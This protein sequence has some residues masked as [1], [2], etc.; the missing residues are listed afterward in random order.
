M[1]EINQADDIEIFMVLV[2]GLDLDTIAD[3][4]VVLIV[5]IHHVCSRKILAEL[6]NDVLNRFGVY[7]WID[8]Q[9]GL[10]EYI[11]QD[12]FGH[13]TTP[14]FAHVVLFVH[15]WVAFDTLP[16]ILGLG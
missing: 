15:A 6:P 10:S 3:F 11:R 8:T 5:G 16:T 14:C 13:R 9:Q 1:V 12:T 7:L 4:V 2:A